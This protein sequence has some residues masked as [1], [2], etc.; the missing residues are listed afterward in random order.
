MHNMA[1][2]LS[3]AFVICTVDKLLYENWLFLWLFVNLQCKIY[4]Q[5]AKLDLGNLCIC[6]MQV[7]NFGGFYVKLD[8]NFTL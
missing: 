1:L 3:D 4:M 7:V 2:Y 6:Q 8:A 5:S